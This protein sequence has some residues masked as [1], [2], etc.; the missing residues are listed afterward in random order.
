MHRVLAGSFALAL[1]I[2]GC[3]ESPT[4][5]AKPIPG[6]DAGAPGN[7]AAPPVTPHVVNPLADTFVH[8]FEWPWPDVAKECTNFLGPKGFTA[9]QVSPP[10][11][12]A[13]L[14]NFPWWERYQTVDYALDRSRSGTKAEFEDM[15]HTCAAAGVDIYVDL[16]INHT[17]AQTSGTGSNGTTFTKYAY[18]GLYTTDDFHQPTC[19]IADADYTTNATHVR[20]CELLGLADLDTSA[21]HVRAE[22]SGYISALLQI[23]VRGFRVDAAKHISP[24]DLNAIVALATQAAKPAPPPYMFFEVTYQPG[25]IILPSDYFR[26]GQDAGVTAGVTEFGYGAVGD[27]FLNTGG[28]TISALKGF[29]GSLIPSAHAVA[30]VLNHDTERAQALFYQDAPYDDLANVFLLAWPYGYP[31][32]LSGY[33]FNR[34][35]QVGRDMGPISDAEGRTL[36]IYAAGSDTPQCALPRATAPFGA[37]TCEHRSRAVANMVGFRRATATA[38]TAD[39][40]WDDG[41]N[42]IAFAR[43]DRGFVAIN[44]E[45]SPLARTFPTGLPAGTYCDVL[46]G[47]FANGVCS[48]PTV[49]VDPSGRA[50]VAVAGGDALAIHAGAKLP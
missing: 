36:P 2:A 41:N 48:G 42:Q 11:E 14:A 47:D 32:V 15:V 9:V 3:S 17:T 21:D 5:S 13:V 19:A 8:L 25:E 12:H 4:S 40:W 27:A 45:A 37:W 10:S 16:V 26:V 18:P 20:V 24:D 34:L 1:S 23:G 35:T 29:G 44:R 30:F 43:G 6:S 50:Q 38:P 7:D 39:L 28:Q 33:A 31:S 46:H 49:A 22:I